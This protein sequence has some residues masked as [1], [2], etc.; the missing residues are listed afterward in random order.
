MQDHDNLVKQLVDETKAALADVLARRS[1][2]M[3][4]ARQFEEQVAAKF[5]QASHLQAQLHEIAAAKKVCEG[6]I[7]DLKRELEET[8][9]AV[10]IAEAREQEANAEI[11]EAN[12]I[13]E[14]LNGQMAALDERVRGLEEKLAESDAI[15]QGL[16]DDKEELR[17]KVAELQAEVAE[18][19]EKHASQMQSEVDA[20]AKANAHL[21]AKAAQLSAEVVRLETSLSAMQAR[22]QVRPTL[23]ARG[24]TMF[25]ALGGFVHTLEQF[26]HGV[27]ILLLQDLERSA[28]VA[29]MDLAKVKA[30]RDTAALARA[31]LQSELERTHRQ[32][33]ACARSSCDRIATRSHTYPR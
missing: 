16:E 12:V 11:D 5:A 7:A 26:S 9:E 2:A 24:P 23:C 14:D 3:E 25:G 19:A 18:A 33:G 28:G 10:K 27:C 30:E 8:R 6:Q 15:N 13:I 31:N 32:Q 22:V 17:E 29:E 21:T 20:A 1:H 4:A